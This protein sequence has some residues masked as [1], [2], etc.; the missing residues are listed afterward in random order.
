MGGALDVV[1]YSEERGVGI[2][3]GLL[4]VYEFAALV[5]G[6][7][8]IVGGWLSDLVGCWKVLLLIP[9]GSFLSC[10]WGGGLN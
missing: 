4:C 8:V 2:M 3:G 10:L 9:F 7:G 5:A 6:L 1:L